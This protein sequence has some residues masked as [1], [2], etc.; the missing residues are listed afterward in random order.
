MTVVTMQQVV[1]EM[2]LVLTDM[3]LTSFKSDASSRSY[4]RTP[5]DELNI[6]RIC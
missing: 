3:R 1:A 6:F 5:N 2:D 4:G